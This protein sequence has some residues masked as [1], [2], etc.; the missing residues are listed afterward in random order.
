MFSIHLQI[1]MISTASNLSVR[2]S[3]CP[4][5]WCV[6][7]NTLFT[8][9]SFNSIL[10]LPTNS[11]FLYTRNVLIITII[12]ITND[13]LLAAVRRSF[14]YTYINH[15]YTC[16]PCLKKTSHRRLAIILTHCNCI[17]LRYTNTLTYLLTYMNDPIM[18]IFGRSVTKGAF[19]KSYQ[20][21][22]GRV[23]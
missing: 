15:N 11:L 8:S 22:T 18:I 6:Q 17:F 14:S 23:W 16:T 12:N 20:N 7:H 5:F 9:L 2:L 10:K 19:F 1:H 4:C 3:H 21:L 13:R